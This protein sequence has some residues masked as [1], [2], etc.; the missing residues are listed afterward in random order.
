MVH[1]G[2]QRVAW[3]YST[4]QGETVNGGY[5]CHEVASRSGG[6]AVKTVVLTDMARPSNHNT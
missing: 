6:E 5:G 3:Q 1:A 2:R 4:R